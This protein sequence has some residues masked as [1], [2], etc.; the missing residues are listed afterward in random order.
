VTDY[1][2]RH[3]WTMGGLQD[4][5]RHSVHLAGKLA[6]DWHERYDTAFSGIAEHLYAVEQPPTYTDLTYAGQTAIWQTVRAEL[7]HHGHYRSHTDLAAHGAGSSP[8]FRAFWSDEYRSTTPSAEAGIV[9]R[10]AVQQILPLLTASELD[11]LLALAVTDDYHAAADMLGISYDR[12]KEHLS[13]ARR[14]LRLWWHEG[15]QPSK[16]WGCDRRCGTTRNTRRETG[17]GQG[18]VAAM[19]RRTRAKADVSEEG[20]L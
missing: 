11:A 9:E 6:S 13:K 7:H 19:R 14:R 12:F 8:R 20:E 10:L 18:A 17:G 4:A 15:E 5:A 16:Q 3:G 2:L 1:Y